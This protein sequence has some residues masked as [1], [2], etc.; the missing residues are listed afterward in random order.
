M[1]GSTLYTVSRMLSAWESRGFVE[2]GREKITLLQPENLL[3][4]AEGREFSAD[5]KQAPL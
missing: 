5:L 4:I 2:A 1:I 3:L